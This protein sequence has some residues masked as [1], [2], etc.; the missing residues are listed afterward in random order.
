MHAS[1]YGQLACAA[2]A[3]GDLE[4]AE[5]YAF[6][7]EEGR[8]LLDACV[9]GMAVRAKIAVLR[10]ELDAALS[11]VRAACAIAEE[12]VHLGVLDDVILRNALIDV[13]LARGETSE[14]NAQIE[15]AQR[16]LASWGRRIEGW[17]TL[18]LDTDEFARVFARHEALI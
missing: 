10:D 13:L 15:A 7:A 2:F 9:V 16:S 17:S 1:S 5:R 8:A 6:R 4:A 18:L 12:G 14:A 3:E 11:L